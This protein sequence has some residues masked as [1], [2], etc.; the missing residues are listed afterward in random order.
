MRT[1]KKNDTMRKMRNFEN[2]NRNF[3]V[4]KV[5]LP[6]DRV[7][8]RSLKTGMQYMYSISTLEGGD[9]KKFTPRTSR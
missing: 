6:E 7:I 8:I 9:F 2:K 4:D 3:I 1:I 5:Y